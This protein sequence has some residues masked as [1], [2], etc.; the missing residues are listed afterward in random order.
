MKIY[1]ILENGYFGGELEVPDGT[2]GIPLYT[3]RTATP[4]IPE[5]KFAFWNGQGWDLV[6]A[7]PPVPVVESTTPVE[8][9]V[10]DPGVQEPVVEPAVQDPPPA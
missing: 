8:P 9:V 10:Q 6:D 2:Q 4:E 7:P 1:Q 5:G 3:T